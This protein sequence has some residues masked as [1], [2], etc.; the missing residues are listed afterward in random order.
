MPPC[1]LQQGIVAT[2]LIRVLDEWTDSHGE[3]V[4]GGN[5]TGIL[6]DDDVRAADGAVWLRAAVQ[7][8]EKKFPRVPPVLAAEVAGRDEG[9]RSLVAKAQWYLARGVRV[10]WVLL[11]D[12]REVIVVTSDGTLRRRGDEMLPPHHALPDLAPPASAFFGRLG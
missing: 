9:E 5:E 10:V 8:A 12:T 3:F 6:L 1:G 2:R 7:T 4:V 11:P